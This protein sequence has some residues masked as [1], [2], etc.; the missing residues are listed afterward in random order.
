VSRPALG[1]TQP[2]IQWVPGALSQGVKRWRCETRLY[3]MP[4]SRMVEL[5][6]HST[7][8]SKKWCINKHR[9]VFIFL[10]SYFGLKVLTAMTMKVL[11]PGTWCHAVRWKWTDVSV[12][13]YRLLL[14]GWRVSQARIHHEPCSKQSLL[15]I[16]SILK[17]KAICSPEMSVDFR[18]IKWCYI[19]E[20][21]IIH[22]Q[23]ITNKI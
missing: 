11:S 10:L 2:P 23:C 5:H 20:N 21:R 13:R 1:P 12:W 4:R 6:L 8:I 9:D 7:Y 3:L 16:S 18:G 22:N 14:Q 19:P 17:M 15:G